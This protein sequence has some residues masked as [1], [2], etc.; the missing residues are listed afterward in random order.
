MKN[1]YFICP[2]CGAEV[3]MKALACP[4]CGADDL[5]GWSEDTLYDG[6]DFLEEEDTGSWPEDK[7]S[8]FLSRTSLAI[9]AL[10]ALLLFLFFIL[11]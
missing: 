2:N 4:E 10:L 3:A 1:D 7:P 9:I 5:T 8:L 6:I 11:R